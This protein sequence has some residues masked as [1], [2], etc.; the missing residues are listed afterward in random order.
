[1]KYIMIA[2]LV[3]FSTVANAQVKNYGCEMI[4]WRKALIEKQSNFI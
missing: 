3:L 4:P 1:M 2:F